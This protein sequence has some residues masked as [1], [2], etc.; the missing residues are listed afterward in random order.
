MSAH[1]D[2]G[3][4]FERRARELLDESTERLEGRIRS[5]LTQAR[6]AAVDEARKPRLGVAWRAWIPAGALAGAAA[7]AVFLWSGAPHSPGA[8]AL[9][10]HS[11]LDDL[12]IMVTNESFELLEDLE[13]YEWVASGDADSASIG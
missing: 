9:A 13:F 8:P 12:D 3:E 4:G 5:R 1:D 11:S 10:V 2:K 6:S 7:L